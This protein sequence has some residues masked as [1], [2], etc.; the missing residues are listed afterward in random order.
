MDTKRVV[1]TGLG[2]ICPIGL[3]IAEFW[4]NLIAG[5]SGASPISRFDTTSHQVKVAAEVKGFDPTKHLDLKTIQRTTR[6]VHFAIPATQEA[7]T[8]AKLDMT[9]EHPE[10]VGVIAANML[11][12]RYIGENWE[13]LKK[14][15]P[16]RVDP[17]MSTKG[18]PSS[19][20]LQVG[21]LL[22][23][24]GRNVTVNSLCASGCDIIA[25]ALNLI[26]LDYADVMV[27]VASGCLTG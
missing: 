3:S 10:R 18:G 22:G 1:I 26:R 17:L 27:A 7:V 15:G 12:N 25:I 16:R 2:V 6:A 20:S 19:V 11:Q 5:K 8:Q 24:K 14:R 21:M 9:K 23:A 13:T 4:E